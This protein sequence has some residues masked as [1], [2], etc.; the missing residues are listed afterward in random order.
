MKKNIFILV[1]AIFCFS[2]TALSKEFTTH[3]LPSGQ[4][5]I[6]KEIHNNPIVTIDTWVKTGSINEDNTNYG[7]AHFLEHMFFKGTTKFPSGKFDQI[8]ESKGAIT[9]AA[10]SKD[11]THYYIVIPSKDFNLAME[12][13]SDMLLNPV[14]PRNELEM[15]RKVVL[16]E[17]QRGKDNPNNILYKSMNSQLYTS[18][19]YKQDVIGLAEIIE[20][21]PREKLLDFYNTWYKPDNMVTVVVGDVNT[22]E[23]IKSVKENF[24][25]INKTK[26]KR[27]KY[28]KD[29]IK[30][31]IPPS[32]TNIDTETGYL[33]IGFRGV[34]IKDKKDSAA[35][36]VLSTILGNGKSSRLYK[37]IQ[38][39]KKLST[40]IIAGHASYKDDSQFYI[41]ATFAPDNQTEIEN[42]IWK[43]LSNITKTPI[44][45]EE[46]EKA[47][48]IIKNDTL[49]S[50]ESTSNIAN[51][52]GYIT[53]LMNSPKYYEKY[54]D[55]IENV[56][57]KDILKVA[58]KYLTKNKASISYILPKDFSDEQT[59]NE[60]LSNDTQTLATQKLKLEPKNYP[61][62]KNAKLVSEIE[63]SKKY[64]LE[65]G[66]TLI[67]T[68]N[69]QNDIIA[70]NMLSKGGYFQEP[71]I[72]TGKLLS[73]LLHK[74][75][76]NYTTAQ[77]SDFLDENGI[78][79]IFQMQ[80]DA[81]STSV[82]STKD[83]FNN[84][85]LIFDEIINNSLLTQKDLNS[86]REKRLQNIK[87]SKDL[88]SNVA[89]DE[90]KYLLWENT[91]YQNS[92]K[93]LEKEYKNIT[94][95]DIKDLYSKIYSPQNTIISVNGNVNDQQLINYFSKVFENKN[96][97]TYN[98]FEFQQQI[99]PMIQDKTSITEKQSNQSWIVIAYR[100]PPITNHKD[101]ATLKV[102]DSILGT[103]MSSR[104]F[105]ELRD[106]KGLAYVVASSYQSNAL[107]GAFLTYI[108]TN[109]NNIEEAK[110]GMLE[111][112]KKFQ[113]NF[114]S[115][116]ELQ[117][118]KD[119][120]IG[121]YI[122][123]QETNSEKAHTLSTYELYD[124]GFD[125]EKKYYE[126]IN[127]VTEQDV[128]EIA[129]KYF[130]EPKVIIIVK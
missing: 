28:K 26:T 123:S 23:V 33:L 4:T 111:Q 14:L 21:I 16:E 104:L 20:T 102:I 38:E 91:P 59:T 117:Q 97:K 95:T 8:L 53:T 99:Y 107:Q 121:N 68:Q 86:A 24:N 89:I 71:K 115:S 44:S 124:K 50:R 43:E 15:E 65:N 90:M 125:F 49:Y 3:K 122:L 62:N 6:I 48:N 77:I 66:L 96:D 10:T 106:Q 61:L 42:E 76:K 116:K 34:N 127:N 64:Q 100:T 84:A 74:D 2:Q 46:I 93:V 126:L 130:S 52:I 80:P 114:I 25:T 58:N 63:N 1:L 9:N 29:K 5:L 94:T 128:I 113:T 35:L 69:N 79:I 36:D 108:G 67:I 39:E 75:T 92:A 70:I 83:E 109:P 98:L 54:L 120:I 60:N 40:S 30:T 45:N 32:I 112:L 57:A 7:V 72:G 27:I 11:Y 129:N 119:Q 82:K 78:E 85:L 88:P 41:K 37:T 110:Q 101:W 13:H 19:P 51:E 87:T 17:M 18:H 12:L 103:G 22:K 47:K 31:N 118:A 73:D 56:T 81:F 55:E 105:T